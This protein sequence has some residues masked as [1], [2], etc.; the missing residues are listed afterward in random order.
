MNA[1]LPASALPVAHRWTETRALPAFDDLGFLVDGR[2]WTAD[3]AAQLAAAEGIAVLGGLHW[4][5]IHLVRQR[6][7]EL[8]ALPVMRLVCRAAGVDPQRA[9]HL[10]GSCRSL[11]R[12]AGL[13]HPGDEVLAYMN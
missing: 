4:T 8:G 13:P 3:L 2:Q 7:H 1:P 10:F 12:I 9:H 6:Y 11:W 5:V